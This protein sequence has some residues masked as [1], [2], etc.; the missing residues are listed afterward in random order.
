MKF[1]LKP[2]LGGTIPECERQELPPHPSQLPGMAP[3]PEPLLL[4][5]LRAGNTRDPG[6]AGN[7]LLQLGSGGGDRYVGP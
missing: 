6:K 1:L 2:S 3:V 7:Y 5:N 4:P